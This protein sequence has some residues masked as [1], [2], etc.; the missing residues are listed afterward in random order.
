MPPVCP[1]DHVALFNVSTGDTPASRGNLYLYPIRRLSVEIVLSKQ[2]FEGVSLALK[3]SGRL[4]ELLGDHGHRHFG[5]V[6]GCFDADE[7]HRRLPFAGESDDG[8]S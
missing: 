7:H 2:I 4:Q 8:Q 5:A 3:R 6:D 1:W